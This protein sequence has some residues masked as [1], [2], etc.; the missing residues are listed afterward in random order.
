MIW[1][2]ANNDLVG[3][4]LSLA[5]AGREM[6]HVARQH[7]GGKDVAVVVVVISS[8]STGIGEISLYTRLF[9]TSLAED[10]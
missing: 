10:G 6:G 3:L 2:L 4:L 9:F 1:L 5:V 8:R 7:A